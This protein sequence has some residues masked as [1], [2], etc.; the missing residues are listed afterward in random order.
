[1]EL[2]KFL[3]AVHLAMA[4][5]LSFDA[6]KIYIDRWAT[7]MQSYAK[8]KAIDF[9]VHPDK[10]TALSDIYRVGNIPAH[11]NEEAL[12]VTAERCNENF[13]RVEQLLPPLVADME[14]LGFDLEAGIL[15]VRETLA[16]QHRAQK[17]VDAIMA[18]TNADPARLETEI[19]PIIDAVLEELEE[20]QVVGLRKNPKLDKRIHRA[21]VVCVAA[22]ANHRDDCPLRSIANR[23]TQIDLTSW[24]VEDARCQEMLRKSVR[25]FPLFR[26]EIDTATIGSGGVLRHAVAYGEDGERWP[27]PGSYPLN[28]SSAPEIFLMVRKVFGAYAEHHRARAGATPRPRDFVL[29]IAVPKSAAMQDWEGLKPPGPRP[30]LLD[31]FHAVTV[32]PVDEYDFPADMEDLLAADTLAFVW[33]S[34]PP[35]VLAKCPNHVVLLAGPPAWQTEIDGLP[36]VLWMMSQR[37]G[38]ALL[39]DEREETALERLCLGDLSERSVTW[40]DLVERL[41]KLKRMVGRDVPHSYRIFLMDARYRDLPAFPL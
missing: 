38:A 22:R 28:A 16:H 21:L 7:T 17:L 11:E 41:A 19:W 34:D 8:D 9:K 4:R 5:L 10:Y 31:E 20:R 35:A 37:A 24:L 15:R 13:R 33:E 26:V 12:L 2:R 14:A 39:P 32:D 30:S 23:V 3:E 18:A 6:G 1:M 27:V 36:A 40:S 25:R 29:Q